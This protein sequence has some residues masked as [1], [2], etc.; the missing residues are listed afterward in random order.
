MCQEELSRIK[1]LPNQSILSTAALFPTASYTN[2]SYTNTNSM[3]KWQKTNGRAF[4]IIG[5]HLPFII[6]TPDNM[7]LWSIHVPTSTDRHHSS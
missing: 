6:Y 3:T 1:E 5:L 2:K 4:Q 7:R